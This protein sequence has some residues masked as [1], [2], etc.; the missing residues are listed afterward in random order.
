M[1]HTNFYIEAKNAHLLA[2]LNLLPV[3]GTTRKLLW[4]AAKDFTSRI[5]RWTNVYINCGG[6]G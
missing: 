5:L 4:R 1:T 3:G 6:Y 2:A